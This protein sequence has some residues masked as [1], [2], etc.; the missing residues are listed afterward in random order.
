[1]Q[2]YKNKR[3]DNTF[4]PALGLVKKEMIKNAEILGKA[5]TLGAMMWISEKA[6]CAVLDWDPKAFKLTLRV[7]PKSQTLFGEVSTIRLDSLAASF[8]GG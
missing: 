1:M 6:E 5:I 7:T 4:Q 3:F 2:I 8:F